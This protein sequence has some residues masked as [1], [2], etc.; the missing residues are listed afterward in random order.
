M[1]Q[2]RSLDAETPISSKSYSRDAPNCF[3]IN[4]WMPKR[5]SAPNLALETTKNASIA[6]QLQICPWRRLKCFKIDP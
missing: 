1:L 6:N 4:P 2:N 3:K 5:P